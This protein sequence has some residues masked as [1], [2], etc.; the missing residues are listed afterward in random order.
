MESLDSPSAPL[1]LKTI[2]SDSCD[3]QKINPAS[4]VVDI[5]RKS[6]R[7]CRYDHTFR[8]TS[9]MGVGKQVKSQA[10]IWDIQCKRRHGCQIDTVK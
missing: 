2:S 9:A 7:I 5:V 3:S 4:V 8:K 10:K 1:K 6:K